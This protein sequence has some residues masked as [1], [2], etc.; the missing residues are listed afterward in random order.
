MWRTQARLDQ[1]QILCI[2]VDLLNKIIIRFQDDSD[3]SDS[4]SEAVSRLPPVGL[5]P[6]LPQL[7][8]IPPPNPMLPDREDLSS[9]EPPAIPPPTPML[10]GPGKTQTSRAG[11]ATANSVAFGMAL[12]V[13]RQNSLHLLDSFEFGNESG[14]ST[15]VPFTSTLKEG[16]HSVAQFD[17][18]PVSVR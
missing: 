5:A 1:L 7:P 8:V 10:P 4:D 9:T 3:S 14:S 17:F 18:E 13:Q 15:S 12:A 11:M 16:S 2:K 6:I